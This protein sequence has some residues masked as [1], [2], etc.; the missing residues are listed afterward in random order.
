MMEIP[1]EIVPKYYR[2]NP[3]TDDMVMGGKDLADGMVV[4]VEDPNLRYDPKLPDM[5]DWEIDR[6][7]MRN[8]WCRVHN[9][10]VVGNAVHFVG[11]YADGTKR[12]SQVTLTYSWLFKIDSIPDSIQF[13]A[14]RYRNIS[15]MVD[16]LLRST[17]SNDIDSHNRH[18]QD[19]TKQILKVL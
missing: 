19:I 6:L 4:L 15:T 11:A 17:P 7:N 18:V 3:K 14:D 13:T 5:D 12:K 1:S 16:A 10:H 8:R 9:V 2:M